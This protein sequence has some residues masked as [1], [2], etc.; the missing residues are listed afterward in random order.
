M[1]LGYIPAEINYYSSKD[2]AF[3][4][5]LKKAYEGDPEACQIVARLYRTGS[6][7]VTKDQKKAEYW[8]HQYEKFSKSSPEKK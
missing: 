4:Y 7:G 3:F 2:N 8:K 5:V 1:D 6:M